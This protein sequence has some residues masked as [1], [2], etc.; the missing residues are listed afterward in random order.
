MNRA[1]TSAAPI[2]GRLAQPDS[3]AI[4][5]NRRRNESLIGATTAMKLPKFLHGIGVRQVR[6]ACGF[7]LF[8]YLLSHF[9]NHSL[10]NISLPAM[11]YGLWFHMTW[12]QSPIGTLLLYPALAV[13]AS[14]G[15]WALYQRRHFRWKAIEL[16]QLIFG[17]SIPALLCTHLIGQRLGVTLYGLQRSYAQT[18]YNLWVARPDFAVMQ[19]TVLLVAW[20][21]GCI[22]LYLWLRMKRF[23]P[24]VAPVLLGGAVLLP[25]LALLGF[26]QQGRNVAQLAQ[27]PEWRA[28]VVTPARRGT[29]AQRANLAEIRDY[30]LFA[31]AGAI[32]LVFVA[33]GARVWRERRGGLIR[34]TY[35]DRTIRVPRGLTVREASFRHNVPHASVC[36]GKGRCSTCRIRVL[37]DRSRLPKPSARESFV[38]ERV[39]ASIDPAVRLACQLRPQSDIALVPILPPQVNT[40]FVHR[41]SRIHLGEERYVV[42]M[43]VDMRGST[44]MAEKRMPFDTVF[45]INR[46]LGAVSQA[47]MESG[48]QPNQYLGDGLFALFGLQA[49]PQTACRQA[50]NAAAVIAGNVEHLNHVLAGAERDP[51]R[52][53]IGVHAGEVVLGDVGYR[54]AMV[55]TA[56]GDT[57]NVTSRLEAMTKELGCQ[58]VLSDEVRSTAGVAADALPS[59]EVTIRGRADPLTVRMVADAAMLA[60]ILDAGAPAAPSA[61]ATAEAMPKSGPEAPAM[62]MQPT[63]TPPATGVA[64]RAFPE[65]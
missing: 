10:G 15:L 31:Y 26:Y 24:R 62:V 29:A 6:L 57:V 63:P 64:P 28:E 40:A 11:E 45:V 14:L 18:L 49:D 51:I 50:L 7:V 22:G 41:A 23:F 25:V 54:D 58:V 37:G 32:G 17:L 33:R 34:L 43:F 30:F 53:G 2:A 8:S 39:G 65:I 3:P 9:V 20:I 36:G 44:S 42:C 38:L 60:G 21:H 35:P 16:V 5:R 47:V 52:F 61:A 48:G 12:W 56:I 1:G 59:T 4:L 19:V 55:F 27:Q 46:F 13:H